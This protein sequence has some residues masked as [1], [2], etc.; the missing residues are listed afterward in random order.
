MFYI[1]Y[2]FLWLITWI[3]LRLFYI[4]SDI[5]FPVVYYLV[6][7][8]RGVVRMNI[9]K[10]FPEK[11]EKERREIEIKFYRFFCD[12]FVE[13]M[14]EMHIGEK[15]VRNRMTYENTEGIFQ[16][17]D[18]ESL[19]GKHVLLVDDV[20]TTGST[21]EA[22]IKALLQIEGVKVSIFTLAVA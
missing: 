15:E 20:L 19:T 1:L 13:T 16:I 2:A 14:Y 12:L 9:E 21:L 3:P 5:S 10:S 22:C 11:T 8:R 6:R 17:S 4:V 18:K 7:Y